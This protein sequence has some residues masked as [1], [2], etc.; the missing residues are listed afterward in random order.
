MERASFY[1]LT[2]REKRKTFFQ[3]AEKLG[4]VENGFY[5]SGIPSGDSA[6]VDFFYFM[7]DVLNYPIACKIPENFLTKE[8]EPEEEEPE[9]DEDED[10]KIACDNCDQEEERDEVFGV[11]EDDWTTPGYYMVCNKCLNNKAN[12]KRFK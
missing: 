12:K 9:D 4:L 2:A 5:I 11:E 10:D 7:R 3:Y 6:D 1:S 8:E